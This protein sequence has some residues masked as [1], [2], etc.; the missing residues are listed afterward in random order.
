[1]LT[2]IVCSIPKRRELVKEAARNP[3]TSQLKETQKEQLAHRWSTCPLS[4]KPLTK[5]IVS[6]CGGNLYNKDAIIQYL[7]RS[8]ASTI[9]K[10]EADNFLQGRVKSLKDVIELQ[11]ENDPQSR[12]EE[13]WICPITLK[14]LG[15]GVK[16]VYLVPCGHTFSLEATKEMKGDTCAQCGE[17]NDSQR[18]VVPILPM[19]EEEREILRKRSEALATQGLTHSLKKVSGKKRKANGTV[20]EDSSRTIADLGADSKTEV[21][22]SPE[23]KPENVSRSNTPV[24]GTSTP[25]VTNGIKN[26][27]TANL[28]A[29]VLEEGEARKKRRLMTGENE[30]LKS[31]F[32]KTGS[33]GK[34]KNVDFMTRGFSIPAN[35]RHQ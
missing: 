26:A 4:H 23:K 21:A 30:N 5:P 28:T 14:P 16:A 19:T 20:A 12:N 6:D 32:S 7:L 35:A 33:D 11:F 31:L 18:D 34:R 3:T 29:R 8:E 2:T 27:T 1:M 24:L 17:K 13:R 22:H 25:R 10:G 15:P 9:D